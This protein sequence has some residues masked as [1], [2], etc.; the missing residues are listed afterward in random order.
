MINHTSKVFHL[1]YRCNAQAIGF[2]LEAQ[3]NSRAHHVIPSLVTVNILS[4]RLFWSRPLRMEIVL[5]YRLP[6]AM[7][8]WYISSNIWD[9]LPRSMLRMTY[10]LPNCNVNCFWYRFVLLSVRSRSFRLFS[11]L[12]FIQTLS[13]RRRIHCLSRWHDTRTVCCVPLLWWWHDTGSNYAPWRN[14]LN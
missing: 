12:L 1:E 2:C 7:W 3:C 11:S 9:A 6:T 13:P 10:S 8:C 14:R 5:V 4:F